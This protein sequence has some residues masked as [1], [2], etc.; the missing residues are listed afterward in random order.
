ML[1]GLIFSVI[2][3]VIFIS[4][5]DKLADLTD[6]ISNGIK[7]NKENLQELTTHIQESLTKYIPGITSQATNIGDKPLNVD[8]IPE[9]VI[10]LVFKPVEIDGTVI[11]PNEQYE[12]VRA[13]KDV[14]ITSNPEAAYSKISTL[15][16]SI[17]KILEPKMNMD[18][19]KSIVFTIAMLYLVSALA[20]FFEAISM[21]HLANNFA[22]SLRSRISKKINKL[23]LSFFDKHQTGDVLSI[24]TNDVDTIAQSMNGSLST[25]VY[26]VVMFIGTL[27]MMFITNWILALV[28]VITTAIGFLLMSTIL[29]KSQKY[30]VMR[31]EEL[32]KLNG[33]IEEI[34]SGLLVVKAYNG[35]KQAAETFDDLNK[36][37]FKCN[38]M[39]QFLS[40]LMQPIMHFVGNFGYVAVCIVGALMAMNGYISFGIIVAFISYVRMFTSP[41]SQIAQS[42][43][44]IQTTAAASERVFE[45]L[46]EQEM[47]DESSFTKKLDKNKVKGKIEFEDVVFKYDGNDE[48]TIKGFTASVEP[49]QK[50]AIVGPTGAGKTTMV[51]LLMKFYE[52]DSGKIKIDG[53]DISKLTR[54]NV[55]E[56]FTMVLQDTWLFEGTVKENIVYD[57]ED[58][59]IERVKDVC[60]EVGLHHFVKTLPK[61]YDTVLSDN[62]SISAGQKQLL[63]IARGMI[64]DAPFLILDE[65]TSNV[66]T[67]TE[68]LVQK[69]MDKLTENRTSF[70]I[71]HRLSTIKNADLILVMRDGNIVE[72]GNHETLIEKNGFYAE[73]Y[74][75]Q[76]E[77]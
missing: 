42:L 71:A 36:K 57:R 61:N 7:I 48:P 45:F 28:A 60:R 11:L 34:Y 40:G 19:V 20:G 58:V 59:D 37:L 76:F 67:R 47:A 13:M 43:T 52:I 14:D 54:E 66:D 2:S 63:T 24:V 21:T 73:L 1:V 31:Q 5:P 64:E 62:E 6:E 17:Q 65:A 75:S 77:L 51:N 26:S 50:I 29:K 46:D 9:G 35:K 10:S 41:L 22:R 38:K 72:Q 12:F 33:H 49:G 53:V 39:S 56:L 70:I 27:L 25:L 16:E 74:N 44:S 68:E 32:G 8:N 30:F 18:N 69:A 15:P 55:H 4:A 3:S 23:P